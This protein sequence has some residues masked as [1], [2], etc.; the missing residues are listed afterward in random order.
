[1][2]NYRLFLAFALC[3][4]VLGLSAQVP[5]KGVS[6]E[7]AQ[8]RKANIS[9]VS[10]DLTFNIPADAKTPLSGKAVIS[11]NLKEK[12][13]VVFDF[14]GGFSG[15]CTV[16][17]KKKR[18]ATYKHEHILLAAKLLKQGPN[19]VEI[20][21]ASTNKAL[22]RQKDYMYTLFMPDQ[23]LSAF[24]CFEQPD[25]KAR[26]TTTLNVPEGWKSM[27]S[28]GTNPIPTYLYS[29][30]AGNF[31]EK[32]VVKEGCPIRILY[33]Q[34]DP[35][36]VAQLDVISSEIAKSMKYMESYTGIKSPFKEYGLILLP[37][38]PYGGTENPGAIQINESRLLLEKGATKE[39]ELKRIE[40]IA[41]ETSHLWFGNI[42]QLDW[43]EN[44]WEKEVIANFLA[45][46]ITRKQVDSKEN[47]INFLTTYQNRA[48]AIDRT[49]GTH[50]IEQPSVVN[51]S[52]LLYD[53]I[54]Y[55][56]ATVM[57]R[58]LEQIMGA[59]KLQSGLRSF[60][61]KNY[62][63]TATWE[64]LVEIL[65]KSNP[66]VG[67]RQ[68]FE[69]WVKQK[70]M[71]VIHTSYQDGQLVVSQTDPFGRGL[72]W[73]QKFVIQVVYDMNP[74]RTIVVDMQKPIMT[75][76]LKNG[77]PSY[78]IP[79]Y[80]GQGYGRFTL[81]DEY[82]EILPKRLITTRNDLARYALL[83]T[84][85]DNYLL[86]KVAP[87]HF[88]ELYR[89][90]MKE[91]NPIIMETAIDH[92]FKIAFDMPSEQRKTL[93]LCMMDLLGENK[94]KDCRQLIIRKMA[95]NATSP[96]VLAQ[97]ETIWQQQNDPLFD[98]HD[99]MEMAYRLAITNPT[100]NQEILSAERARLKSE[101]LQK[102][103]DFVS[104]ACNPDAS[105]RGDLFKKLLKKDNRKEEPWAI[106]A[107]Q[108]LSTDVYEQDCPG[109]ISQSL[110]NLKYLKQ[111]S[112]VLFPGNWLEAL[113]DSQKSY[114]VK[115]TTENW[116]SNPKNDSPEDLR[117]K[118]YEVSW[119]MRN[120]Q[121]YVE[122]PKPVAVTKAKTATKKAATTT[123]KTAATTKR[124][125]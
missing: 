3:M 38:Y 36:K 19:T 123:K 120:Q 77:K 76:S 21:F 74:S 91:K 116:L 56:K 95:A 26:F 102:E 12:S 101:D 84:I 65:D 13:D 8:Q 92:M 118:V 109:Y 110:A 5:E 97:I 82:A 42:V 11:F 104:R 108:L 59:T 51:H 6:K 80:N 81:D 10:Y 83:N 23:A 105:K 18:Q 100:R 49:D 68:F 14:Q 4:L 70:G 103:F 29:F 112:D 67:V 58:S 69:V 54:I 46:K 66:T 90:M 44:L 39:E 55:N 119:L 43:T 53:N 1:M 60:L 20:D 106:H 47:D 40:L 22:N 41:H 96:D 113:Y 48:I 34:T 50:A 61:Q 99:Y 122:K 16:N 86:G 75:Y 35:Q 7:L 63:K 25:I 62:F 9:N 28:D 32:A 98:E 114:S 87:S 121:P 64:D 72:C 37:D 89:F 88:G 85:H 17:G 45:S 30:V 31:E 15:T 94:S 71:P 125:K 79:N 78:I 124:K 27:A 111:T 115:Q 117:E 107:L 24:P 52:T 2:K 73:P 93:E 57:M 33:R